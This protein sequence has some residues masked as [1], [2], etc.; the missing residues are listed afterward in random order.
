MFGRPIDTHWRRMLALV[1]GLLA[2]AV[3]QADPAVGQW[4]AAAFAAPDDDKADDPKPKGKEDKDDAAD[5]NSKFYQVPDTKDPAELIKFIDTIREYKPESVEDAMVHQKQAP[6]AIKSA[7]ALILKYEKDKSSDAYKVASLMFLA[8]SI[9]TIDDAKP[10]EQRSLIDDIT[11]RLSS[12]KP[13]PEDFRLALMLTRKLDELEDTKLAADAYNAIGKAFKASKDEQIAALGTRLEG[14]AR[15]IDLVGKPM[16]VEGQVIGGK[17]FDWKSY[18]GKVVLVDFWA[19]WCGPCRAE[20]PNVKRAYREYH[21]RGFDV[22]GVSIDDDTEA[23]EQFLVD[24]KIPWVTLHDKGKDGEEGKGE[25]GHPLADYYGIMGIPTVILIGKDSKVVT[26][27]ARGEELWDQLAKLIGPPAKDKGDDKEEKP[28]VE[29]TKTPP[30][31][32]PPSKTPP[33]VKP[34]GAGK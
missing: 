21:S 24:E 12:D 11:K 8:A 10:A 17:T 25:Q 13:S 32:A 33:G 29:P 28:P 1:A 19:T 7:A 23:L 9:S 5:A 26:L 18:A 4:S 20:L 30:T 34:K 16:K 3:W 6:Q 27:N 2:L 14:A 15:R 31:K 22:V